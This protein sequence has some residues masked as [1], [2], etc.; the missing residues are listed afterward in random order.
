MRSSKWHY[1]DLP[2]NQ[3]LRIHTI[4]TGG[5][6]N[7]YID[8]RPPRLRWIREIASEDMERDLH[9]TWRSKI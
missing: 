6:T 7:K 1:W 5:L 8:F 2:V 9:K 3:Q 4:L